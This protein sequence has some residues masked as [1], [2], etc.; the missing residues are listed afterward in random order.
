MIVDS[1]DDW[2][3][4]VTSAEMSVVM[5]HIHIKGKNNGK[6]FKSSGR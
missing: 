2:F 3:E 1:M 4:W 5:R 6:A